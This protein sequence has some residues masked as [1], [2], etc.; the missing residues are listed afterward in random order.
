MTHEEIK[1]YTN[2]WKD[3]PCS[4]N[5]R[6]NIIK[7]S[8]LPKAMYTVNAIPTKIPTVFFT[9]IEQIILIFAWNHKGQQTVKAILRKENRMEASCTLTSNYTVKLQ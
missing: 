3:I 9:E 8:I 1:E 5:G 4:W 6:I 2:K 7:M